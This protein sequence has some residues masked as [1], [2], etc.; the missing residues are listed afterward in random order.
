MCKRSYKS[1]ALASTKKKPRKTTKHQEVFLR[2]N[3][4]F[5]EVLNALKDLYGVTDATSFCAGKLTDPIYTSFEGFPFLEYMRSKDN[6]F[7][8]LSFKRIGLIYI[9]LRVPKHFRYKVLVSRSNKHFLKLFR[10]HCRT[11]RYFKIVSD[12]DVKV[13]DTC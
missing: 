1:F 13:S 12:S 6:F 9:V 2:D 5:S 10:G 4:S 8:L 7:Y 11:C 3:A